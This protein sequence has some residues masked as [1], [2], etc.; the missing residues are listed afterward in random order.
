MNELMTTKETA[1]F[2]RINRHTLYL[3]RR[4]GIGPKCYKLGGIYIYE[5]K[6]IR[7]FL[8]MNLIKGET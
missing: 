7:S 4:K 5:Q 3:W 8:K 6:A 2:L 1:D